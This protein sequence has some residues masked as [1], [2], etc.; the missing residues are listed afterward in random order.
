MPWTLP[1]NR[2]VFLGILQQDDTLTIN[3][4]NPCS[5]SAGQ[6]GLLSRPGFTTKEGHT[7]IGLST[8]KELTAPMDN[9][10]WNTRL[11]EGM[12]V[13]ELQITGLSV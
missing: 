5:L 1:G 7:G 4:K 8:V 6:L 11:E 9:V 12:L 2:S 13:Q 10:F 3:V